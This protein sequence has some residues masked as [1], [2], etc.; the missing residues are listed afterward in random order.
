MRTTESAAS[1]KTQSIKQALR[2][3]RTNRADA[4]KR[5]KTV[6]IKTVTI[7]TQKNIPAIRK[8]TQ[9]NYRM[10]RDHLDSCTSTSSVSDKSNFSFVSFSKRKGRIKC[11]LC[12]S[13]HYTSAC[14]SSPIKTVE[15]DKWI[16]SLEA[17]NPSFFAQLTFKGPDAVNNYYDRTLQRASKPPVRK[18]RCHMCHKTSHYTNECAWAPINTL[19]M[20]SWTAKL[21]SCNEN[22]Y[23]KLFDLDRVRAFYVN[24]LLKM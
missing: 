5:I 9:T 3:L 13:A 8:T 22:L 19:S 10:V 17:A 2:T 4:V 7:Q 15:R 11:R 12:R 18:K 1:E 20:E 24:C 14:T 21:K 16:K 6:P 23:K